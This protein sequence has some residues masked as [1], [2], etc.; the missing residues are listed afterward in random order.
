MAPNI[1]DREMTIAIK[2]IKS[3]AAA[4]LPLIFIKYPG[5]IS[6]VTSKD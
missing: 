1:G 5:I 6:D 2:C 4:A 3:I